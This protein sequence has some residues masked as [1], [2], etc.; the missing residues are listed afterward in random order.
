VAHRNHQA[1]AGFAALPSA[2]AGKACLRAASIFRRRSPQVRRRVCLLAPP[3]STICA[4]M[5][6]GLRCCQ[7]ARRPHPA[8]LPVRVPT[9]EGLPTASF[10]FA[11]QLRLAV[12]LRL[13][14]SAPVGSFDPTRLCPCWAHCRGLPAAAST[15]VSMHGDPPEK[16]PR[17]VRQRIRKRKCP[18]GTQE[19]A[20][21]D[22]HPTRALVSTPIGRPPRPCRELHGAIQSP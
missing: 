16:R 5:T 8:S 21:H 18:G 1:A 13:P 9:V 6:L 14:P 17:H 20:R 11:S 19:C 2:L 7:P 15:L 22:A 4:L 3:G 12:W 10:S